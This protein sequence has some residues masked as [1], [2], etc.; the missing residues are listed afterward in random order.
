[1]AKKTKELEPID[2]KKVKKATSTKKS[3]S[4]NTKK[5]TVKKVAT[6]SKKATTKT[7]KTTKTTKSS[8]NNEKKS[9]TKKTAT[10]KENKTKK[11]VASKSST[12]KKNTTNLKKE[13]HKEDF[14]SEYYDL[15]FMYNKTVV[16]VLAQT[17]K[18]LFIYWEISD[19]DRSKLIDLYGENFFNS[20]KPVLI[21][22]ND[23]LNYSF[24]VTIDDFANSWYLHIDDANCQYHVELGRKP[25][26]HSEQYGQPVY[27][28]YYIYITSSNEMASPNNKILFDFNKTI[29]FKNV[30]TGQI[31][32]K[33]INQFKFI[34]NYGIFSIQDLY[35]Y[36][37][38]NENFEVE[39]IELTGSSSRSGMF[40]SQFK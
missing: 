22:Y 14:K 20:T 3:S 25:I 36:L 12:L 13:A 5:T 15:P 1:M 9:K 24:E 26:N 39:N 27:I 21:V 29:K 19:E 31:I 6:T 32:E 16:K 33:D 34:T 10:S 11:I 30:K 37:Y 2:E 7:S 8:S 17:P 23:T 28:P 35:K 38:P 4:K 40:S 18:M